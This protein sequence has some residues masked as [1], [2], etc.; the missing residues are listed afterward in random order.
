MTANELIQCEAELWHEAT[1]HRFLDGVREGT[2]PPEAFARWLAQDYHFAVALIR[3]EA[4]YLAAAPREDLALLASGVQAMVAELDWFE[5]KAAEH[6]IDLGAPLHP[7]TRAYIDYL[8][9]LCDRPYSVQLTALWAL[10][11]AYL[12]AWHG[13]SPGAQ[14]FREFVE[15]WTSDAFAAYVAALEAVT[16]RVLGQSGDAEH[17]AFRQVARHERA[18]WEMA[19]ESVDG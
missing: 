13:A 12:D 9:A 6:E 5:Y 3:A 7:T 16:S 1:H 10:E 17:E 19:C 8:Y 15:H 2:L 18:F 4:R 14:A 11:R